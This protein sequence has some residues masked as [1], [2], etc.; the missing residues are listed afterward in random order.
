MQWLY[1]ITA[2]NRPRV[3]LRILTIFEQQ[4]IPILSYVAVRLG[5]EICIRIDVEAVACDDHRVRALL[6]RNEDIL[7]IRAIAEGDSASVAVAFCVV[8]E[9]ANQIR[10][11]QVLVGL[12]ASINYVSDAQIVF[13]FEGSESEVQ[14]IEQRLQGYWPVERLAAP[15][16]PRATKTLEKTSSPGSVSELEDGCPASLK[17][18][19]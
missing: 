5:Q 2:D 11:L 14:A 19:M 10:L 17:P 7:A 8:C 16:S 4:R 1:L 9:E 18:R 13:E 6:Y 3:Q 15:V 12:G